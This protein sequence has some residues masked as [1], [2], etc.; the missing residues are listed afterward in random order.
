MNRT[1]LS[2][3]AALVFLTAGVGHSQAP[4]ASGT[5]LSNLQAIQATNRA[6]IEKQQKTLQTLDE[7]KS[8]AEQ[9]KTLTKRG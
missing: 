7:L 3:T 5:M 2:F 8:T 1:Q 4:Q 9:I 6:L